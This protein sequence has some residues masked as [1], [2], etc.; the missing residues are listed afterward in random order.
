[1]LPRLTCQ[2]AF[3]GNLYWFV[4]WTEFWQQ[5]FSWH[6]PLIVTLTTVFNY[7]V[8]GTCALYGIAFA[9]GQWTLWAGYCD[10]DWLIHV[11]VFSWWK[12]INIWPT[13]HILLTNAVSSTNRAGCRKP[14]RQIC[15]IT[16]SWIALWAPTALFVIIGISS[17]LML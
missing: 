8:A 7:T 4:G 16:F 11:H 2:R 14:D 6:Q 12:A 1:M 9:T 3:L 10:S 15:I 5:F 17:K 13:C